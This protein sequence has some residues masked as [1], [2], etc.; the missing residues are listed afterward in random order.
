MKSKL[1]ANAKGLVVN[2]SVEG[3][4]LELGKRG[5]R[6]MPAVRQA[7]KQYTNVMREIARLE[8]QGRQQALELITMRDRKAA[9]A[10]KAEMKETA[11]SLKKAKQAQKIATKKLYKVLAVEASKSGELVQARKISL[12]KAK[13]ETKLSKDLEKVVSRFTSAWKK[14]R[15]RIIRRRLSAKIKKEVSKAAAAR[16]RASMKAK[17]SVIRAETL[18][19]ARDRKA[20]AKTRAKAKKIAAKIKAKMRAAR[21]AAGIVRR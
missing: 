14:R 20:L 11:S 21:K 17:E 15:N 5:R 8:K 6:S 12:Y 1:K 10:V 16:K 7:R 2:T 3:K 9:A 19:K 13:L 18:A 4:M